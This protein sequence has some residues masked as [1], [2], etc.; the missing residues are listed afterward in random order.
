MKCDQLWKFRVLGNRFYQLPRGK[1]G[2]NGNNLCEL[3]QMNLPVPKTLL[4][5]SEEIHS[6]FECNIPQYQSLLDLCARWET[7]KVLLELSRL[8]ETILEMPLPPHF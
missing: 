5:D 7:P 2:R 4:F 3:V 1:F 6:W 8:R